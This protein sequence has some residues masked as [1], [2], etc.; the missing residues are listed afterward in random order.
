MNVSDEPIIQFQL[1]RYQFFG[2]SGPLTFFKGRGFESQV[3]DLA[4]F[5]DNETFSQEQLRGWFR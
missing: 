1:P 2:S 4:I 3:K 5:K